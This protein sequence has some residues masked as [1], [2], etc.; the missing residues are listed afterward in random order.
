GVKIARDGGRV[1][2]VSVEF[3]DVRRAAAELDL[4]LKEVLRAATAAAH[5]AH[6][7]GSR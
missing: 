4:P 5:R 1:V 3:E 7:S 2:N 6:P